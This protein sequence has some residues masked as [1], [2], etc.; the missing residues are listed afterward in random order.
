MDGIRNTGNNST[1][2]YWQS[3]ACPS[4]PNNTWFSLVFPWSHPKQ[5]IFKIM[6]KR[7][8]QWLLSKELKRTTATWFH[9]SIPSE[10]GRSCEWGSHAM[11]G[12]GDSNDSKAR[13]RPRCTLHME[14]GSRPKWSPHSDIAADHWFCPVEIEVERCGRSKQYSK[15]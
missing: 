13:L 3:H 9:T 10:R 6:S 1:R 2:D 7:V 12:T 11:S 8:L 14:L 4:T 15:C 5:N